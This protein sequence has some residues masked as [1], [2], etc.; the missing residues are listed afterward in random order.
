MKIYL[1]FLQQKCNPQRLVFS[2]ISL[3]MIWYREPFRRAVKRK[4]VSQVAILDI[5]KAVSR[6]WC[7]IVGKLVLITSRNS[8]MGFWL[9]PKLVTLTF[10]VSSP[11]E[12]LVYKLVILCPVNSLTTINN[13]VQS[14]TT[15]AVASAS[16]ALSSVAISI[17]C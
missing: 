7:E 4:R 12:F 8:Y 5:S 15:A 3:T 6:K 9:V 17:D 11:G 13:A 16:T 14:H 1:N 10:A 2:D